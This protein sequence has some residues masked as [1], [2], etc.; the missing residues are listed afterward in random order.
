MPYHLVIT[1]ILIIVFL[2]IITNRPRRVKPEGAADQ[3]NELEAMLD[4]CHQ[5]EKRLNTLERITTDPE[6]ELKR[7][8]RKLDGDE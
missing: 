4:R 1:S 8:F 3:E 5:M 7:K 2:V 6:E